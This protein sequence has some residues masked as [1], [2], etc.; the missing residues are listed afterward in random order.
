M[1]PKATP[2]T[3]DQRGPGLVAHDGD[4]LRVA[5]PELGI[6]VGAVERLDQLNGSP[7]A[8]AVAN[9]SRHSVGP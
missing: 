4:A 2:L 9:A 7:P 6:M 5:T 3:R 8:S 1:G